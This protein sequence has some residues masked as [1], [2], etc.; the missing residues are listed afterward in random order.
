MCRGQPLETTR[1]A[2]D[3]MF[4]TRMQTDRGPDPHVQA[5]NLAPLETDVL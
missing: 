1:V 3:G 2:A 5:N 4:E